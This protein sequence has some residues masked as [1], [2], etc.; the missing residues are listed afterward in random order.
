MTIF[1]YVVYFYFKGGDLNLANK[2]R[3][4]K[5]FI[6]K[7]SKQEYQTLYKL[8]GLL[9]TDTVVNDLDMTYEEDDT[10]FKIYREL[11]VLAH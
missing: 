1:E 4:G 10:I 7:L 8:L 11:G 9:E 3:E 2:N 5:K 6:V